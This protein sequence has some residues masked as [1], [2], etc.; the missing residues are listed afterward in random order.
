[1]R[2]ENNFSVLLRSASVP[3]AI[4]E[5][6]EC[7]RS[8]KKGLE[9]LRNFLCHLNDRGLKGAQLVIS[10]TCHAHSTGNEE[11]LFLNEVMHAE[12]H[13]SDC[14]SVRSLLWVV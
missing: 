5:F 1:M 7:V 13:E 4:G 12:N 14:S 8:E 11:T 3:M 9:C 6:L 10:D 2:L